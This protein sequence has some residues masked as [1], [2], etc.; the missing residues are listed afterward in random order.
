MTRLIDEVRRRLEDSIPP[1][2][3]VLS[4]SSSV[5]RQR[6][7]ASK[8]SLDPLAEWCSDEGLALLREDYPR[9]FEAYTCLEV[10]A[11]REPNAFGAIYR[12]YRDRVMRAVLGAARD[13]GLMAN[14]ADTTVGGRWVG[15][16][17][18]RVRAELRGYELRM[19]LED[20]RVI[21]LDRDLG[22]NEGFDA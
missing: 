1:Y 11:A 6:A 20:G 5:T 12:G 3:P 8:E 16:H 7:S 9:V 14:V 15:R 18:P 10:A 17:R 13:A 22:M 2:I 4:G 21:V 19:V